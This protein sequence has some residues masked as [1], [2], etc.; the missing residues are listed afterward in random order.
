M[1][2]IS[3]V[4]LLCIFTASASFRALSFSGEGSGTPSDPYQITSC[5]QLQEMEDDLSACYELM[6]DIDCSETTGWNWDITWEEYRGFDPIGHSSTASF[7]GVFDG[8]EHVISDLYINR[9]HS[10]WNGYIWIHAPRQ[11][12]GLFGSV[13]DPTISRVGLTD[14]DISGGSHVGGLVG[15]SDFGHGG[16]I[17]NCFVTGD[18]RSS[19][20]LSLLLFGN[21][22]GGLAGINNGTI[23]D[24]YADVDLTAGGG[25]AFGGFTGQNV[26]TIT[27][28]YAIGSVTVDESANGIGGIAGQS[29]YD[30]SINNCFAASAITGSTNQAGGIIGRNWALVSNCCWDVYIST[31]TECAGVSEYGGT[32]DCTGVN[33]SNTEPDYFYFSAHPPLDQW[34]FSAVWAVYEGADYPFLQWQA[35]LPTPTFT[36]SSAPTSAS[37]SPTPTKTPYTPEGYVIIPAGEYMMGSPVDEMCRV[38]NETLHEVI[39][40][41]DFFMKKCEVT[42]AEWQ[43][44]FGNNPSYFPGNNRPVERITWYDAVIYCN[45][46][47]QNESL[48]PCYYEDAEFTTVFDG[49]PPVTEGTVYWKTDAGGY[50]LPTESEWEYACRAGTTTAYNNGLDNLSCYE[51][52]ANLSPLAWY[53]INSDDQTHDVMQKQENNWLLHDMH[54]NI[55]EWVWDWLDSY[56]PG[57]VVDPAGPESGMDKIYRGGCWFDVPMICR[58]A[59][60][61]SISPQYSDHTI[62]FRTVRLRPSTT[63]TPAPTPTTIPT[64]A[65]V[66]ASDAAGIALLI[67]ILTVTLGAQLPNPRKHLSSH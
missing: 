63:P 27:D 12:I 48:T 13:H 42:Q 64:P 40:T 19:D 6:N 38:D 30:S 55:W 44:V 50:R 7:T 36:P 66:P 1:R 28:C 54:G 58:S 34:D 14:V 4:I 10:E 41:N 37:P 29:Y 8:G 53:T 45:R 31:Q 49:I 26:G 57:P 2:G 24:C 60:R 39:L 47:S 9:T 17:S 20:E 51:Y 21:Y 18:V 67:V 22:A 56:P 65:A 52:D 43:S 15:R 62:G 23:N 59:F 32:A 16:T 33:P 11:D 5:V 35:A 61:N 25:Q 3:T 46:I